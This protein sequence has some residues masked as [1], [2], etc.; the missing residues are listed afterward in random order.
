[1]KNSFKYVAAVV[2]ILIGILY[3][4]PKEKVNI[5]ISVKATDDAVRRHFIDKKLWGKWFPAKQIN[6]S[7]FQFDNCTYRIHKLMLNGFE[8]SVYENGDTLKGLIQVIS[9]DKDVTEILWSTDNLKPSGYI[10]S[11]SNYFKHKKI[12]NNIEHLMENIKTFF[13]DDKNI[14]GFNVVVER[15]KDFSLLVLRKKYNQKPNSKN[16]Y[17]QIEIIEN[18]TKEINA[19]IKNKPMVNIHS[20]NV[21]EYEL[22]VAIPTKK[23]EIGKSDIAFKQLVEGNIL[24]ANV[25]GGELENEKAE[26]QMQLYIQD[27]NKTSPATPYFS[28]V[29]DRRVEKDSTKWVSKLYYPVFY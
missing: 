27:N 4:L 8:T 3:F 24:V 9:N 2:I 5:G 17:E 14:Y 26:K 19:E 13:D 7:I 11:L 20:E 16:I 1:M 25:V 21:N 23:D 28:L 18:Y 6:D 12:N 22:M 29:T 15:T 10:E